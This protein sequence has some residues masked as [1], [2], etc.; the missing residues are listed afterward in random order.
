MNGEAV[1]TL[2][3]F[4]KLPIGQ[5][6]SIL[7]FFVV[8]VMIFIILSNFIQVS[9]VMK[10]KNSEYVTESISQINQ[11]IASNSDVVKRLLEKISYNSPIVQSYLNETDSVRKFVEYTQLKSYIGDMID[12]KD[13][14]LDIA[15]IDNNGT[16]F[17]T[18]GDIN[19]LLPFREEIPERKLYY[20]SS[21]QTI[22][23]NS[24]M[25]HVFIAGTRIYSI[26]NFE[27][28][29]VP[30]GTLLLVLD[31]SAMLGKQEQV[32]RMSGSEVYMIDRNGVVFYTN[33]EEISVGSMYDEAQLLDGDDSDIIRTGEIPDLGGRVIIKVPASA[34]LS[35]VAEI[36]RQQ[37]LV[38]CISLAVLAFPFLFVINNILYPLKKLLRFMKEIRSGTLK[39]LKKRIELDG[40]Y[41]MMTTTNHF[42]AMLDEI[43]D[44]THKLLESNVRLYEA[45]L[46]KKKSELAFLQSQINPHFL[47]NTL[48]SIKGIAADEGSDKIFRISKALALVFRYSIKGADRIPLREEIQMIQNYMYIQ[49]IRFG[50]RIEMEYEIDQTLLD[51]KV[52]RM[53]LQPIVE[54]AVFH[55]MEPKVGG[56]KLRFEAYVRENVLY[57]A[58]KDSGVGIKRDTLEHIQA[59]LMAETRLKASGE[60]E[61]YIEGIGLFNVHDR[62]R[63]NYGNPYGVRVV[64]MLGIGTEVSILMPYGGELYA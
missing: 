28:K 32:I 20:Y 55:G 63:L 18:S 41:E 31:I 35:E 49:Q 59:R 60:M 30:I 46:V 29:E 10:E 39:T 42:N 3:Y 6:L 57:L 50:D 58:V 40:Y 27:N 22:P 15:M 1:K 52:P 38:F 16:V 17:N 25:R 61:D 23:F 9:R 62:I 47:Y 56:C 4:K 48:E 36:R 54:N 64:S 24:K 2:K 51:Y 14:I 43:D 45:E 7:A 13:G 5:Q 53:I 19:E 21:L 44:L 8:A 12:M 33:N 26:T 11:T 37:L 34:L